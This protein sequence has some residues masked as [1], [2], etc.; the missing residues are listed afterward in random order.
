[1]SIRTRLLT[2]IALAIA[3]LVAC[4]AVFGWQSYSALIAEKKLKTR[5]LV[6]AASGVLEYWRAKQ[7]AG[8]ID[9]ATAKREAAAAIKALR[10]E[11]K[12]YFWIHDLTAP[13][14]KMVMHPTVPDLD[15]KVLNS[16]RFNRATSM[17]AG[18]DG[19]VV[20]TDGKM[21][22]F[23]AMN[24]VVNRAGSGFVTYDWPKPLAGG[25]A[26]EE[27]YPKLSYVK[28]F[29]DWGWVIGTGIYVD[30]VKQ[31]VWQMMLTDSAVVALIALAL[32]AV[33]LVLANRIVRSLAATATL[34]RQAVAEDDFTRHVPVSSHDEVGRTA[35]AFN[36]LMGKLREIV[37]ETRQSVSAV[38][39][40]AQEIAAAAREGVG[41]AE[42][43]SHAASSV[44]AA[45]E[46]ISSSLSTTASNARE[47]ERAAQAAA[48]EAEASVRIAQEN[49]AR[50]EEVAAAIR[51]S[52]EKVK[53]LSESSSRINVIV[54]VIKEIADQ[55]NLLALNA[56]IE[57][58]RAGEQGRG[59][60]VVADE[61][62]KLAEKTSAATQEIT[63]LIDQI[64]AQVQESTDAMEA[65]DHRSA[66]GAHSARE[67]ASAIAALVQDAARGGE[68]ARDIANAV[69]EQDASVQEIARQIE[70]LAR[71]SE[72]VAAAAKRNDQ[73]A[74]RLSALANALSGRVARYKV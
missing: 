62:R 43:Q 16:E 70:T 1:M 10:Y 44:A 72:D 45:I 3:A 69:R 66:E 48:A 29:D 22:L 6:E 54:A 71:M 18:I 65:I 41:N 11:G 50:M 20:K 15:G 26:T 2:I 67:A 14:P 61:V 28:K 24:E 7:K 32:I 46:E 55:T 33:S 23:V 40:A 31:E 8:E 59:F 35:E 19:P 68:R 47:S 39:A 60:A 37:L 13:V 21:N 64:N 51:D 58:A 52:T 12:E 63:L 57:A 4:I 5:H 30:D 17:Q 38:G 53:Q 27:L 25:G 34:S 42:K 49:I 74:E 56:A 73:I 36:T 9:E